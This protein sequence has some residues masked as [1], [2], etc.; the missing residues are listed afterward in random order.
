[1]KCH[2]GCRCLPCEQ[3]AA[4]VFVL[5]GYGVSSAVPSLCQPIEC[6]SM[7]EMRENEWNASKRL[8]KRID[9]NKGEEERNYKYGAK[10]IYVE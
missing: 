10:T 4:R 9:I 6:K 5:S 2:R 3:Y 8:R 7:S 1:M